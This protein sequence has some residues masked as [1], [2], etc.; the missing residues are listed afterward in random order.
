M[1]LLFLVFTVLF[2]QSHAFC[3][4]LSPDRVIVGVKLVRLHNEL[5][6]RRTS[7]S[8][9][10]LRESEDDSEDKVKVGS[11]EYYKGFLES[12]LDEDT[13]PRGDGLKQALALA[14]NATILLALLTAAFLKSNGVF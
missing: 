6:L 5:S 13:D 3:S 4:I 9:S 1:Y 8:S 12:S 10:L 11:K 14:G 2:T 7:H